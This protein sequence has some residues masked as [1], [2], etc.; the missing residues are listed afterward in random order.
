MASRT[1]GIRKKTLSTQHQLEHARAYYHANKITCR[2]KALEYFRKH[3]AEKNAYSREYMRRNRE[4]LRDYKNQN[5]AKSRRK[6]P[7][8]HWARRLKYKYGISLKD[9]NQILE[10]QRGRCAICNGSNNYR[11]RWG[12][13][14]RKLMVD[15]CHATG[16]VR[17]LLCQRCNLGI[18]YFDRKPSW[19]AAATKYLSGVTHAD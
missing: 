17:G 9:Y 11:S 2:R 15:H 7:D 1:Y 3:K 16:L 6:N 18:S 4:R 14:I 13:K 12:T 10:K 8:R 19:L 5:E